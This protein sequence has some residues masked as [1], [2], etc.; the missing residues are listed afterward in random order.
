MIVVSAASPA[1]LSA[2][3]ARRL[4]EPAHFPG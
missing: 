3:A 2:G 4:A 1:D